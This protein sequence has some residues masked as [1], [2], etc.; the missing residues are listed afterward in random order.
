MEM[1]PS[2][3]DDPAGQDIVIPVLHEEL[4]VHKVA[5]ETGS[6]RIQK[7][8]HE[9]EEFISEALAADSVEIERIPMDLIVENPP[10]IRTE[11][12]V[13]IIPVIREV[14]VLT[15]Q[16]RVVEELRITR[17]R[18]VVDHQQTITLR[19]EEL[20]IQRQGSRD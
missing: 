3:T 2:L 5:R 20:V 15:K 11:G 14:L 6:V 16:L 12:D 13:T 9:S 4:A 10:A 7:I 1:R 19:A 8:V 18:S 17:H